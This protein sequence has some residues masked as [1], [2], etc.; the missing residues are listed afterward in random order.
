MNSGNTSKSAY[1][2][3]TTINNKTGAIEAYENIPS[4]SIIIVGDKKTPKIADGNNS[5][6]FSVD[7][8]NDLGFSILNR[9]PYNHYCRKNIG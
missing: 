2:V 9:L 8:Q 4:V 3:I 7:V 5:H 6:Y 1:V